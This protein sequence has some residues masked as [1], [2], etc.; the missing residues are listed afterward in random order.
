MLPPEPLLLLHLRASA[1][2][3]PAVSVAAATAPL[4][5]LLYP[6]SSVTPLLP[7]L[8]VHRCLQSLASIQ[9]PT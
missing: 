1:I 8:L 4:R 9:C 2:A 7:H 3:T 5:C 6:L